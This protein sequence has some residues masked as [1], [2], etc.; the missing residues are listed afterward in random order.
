MSILK[1]TCHLFFGIP[2]LLILDTYPFMWGFVNKKSQMD[3][4]GT[5]NSL[6]TVLKYP[7]LSDIHNSSL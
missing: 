5:R 3:I 4:K 2:N 1:T 6:I 7:K